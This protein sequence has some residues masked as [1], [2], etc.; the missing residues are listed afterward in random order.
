MSPATE[1]KIA[2]KDAVARN[3]ITGVALFAP[4]TVLISKVQFNFDR[5]CPAYKL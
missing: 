5:M 1:V 3:V 2:P 4:I